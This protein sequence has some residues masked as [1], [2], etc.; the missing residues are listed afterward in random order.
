MDFATRAA[1]AGVGHDSAFRS[2]STPIYQTAIFEHQKPLVPGADPYNYTRLGNPTRTALEQALAEL[3]GGL[4]AFAFSSGMAAIYAAL[5]TLKPGDHIIA[6]AGLYGHTYAVIQNCLAPLGIRA[7]YVDT[8]SIDA[9]LSAWTDA[10]AAVYVEMPSNPLLRA[11]DLPALAAICKERRAKLLVDSTFLTPWGIRPLELGADIVLHSATKYLAGHNDTMAGAVIVRS[12]SLA[13]EI[14]MI[15]KLTGSV[16]SPFDSW[17]TL[18][19]IKTLALRMERAQA[20]AMALAEWLAAHPRVTEVHYPG[21]PQHPDR[22]LFE[23]QTSS[24]GSVLSFA[25]QSRQAAM[26][27]LERTK[28]ILIAESLGGVESLM[29]YP[30]TQTHQNIPPAERMRLGIH[31][32]LLRLSVGIESVDDLKAD[33]AQAL[34]AV[35]E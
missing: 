16:L 6:T 23:R 28:L 33:L 18:R 12:D 31:D 27:V 30:W 1:R 19:G 7:D 25:L 14:S 5:Q 26:R 24:F 2:V 32:R 11:A 35:E 34:D 8:S 17:L 29:T 15:H 21:L 22:L 4:Y 3:E 10:T 9:V 20:N 13:E